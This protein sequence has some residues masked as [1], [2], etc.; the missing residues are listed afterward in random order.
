MRGERGKLHRTQ[1]CL[2]KPNVPTSSNHLAAHLSSQMGSMLDFISKRRGPCRCDGESLRLG[3]CSGDWGCVAATGA[4]SWSLRRGQCRCDGGTGNMVN[5]MPPV[6]LR[7]G[8]NE[9][10]RRGRARLVWL[11]CTENA[12][13]WRSGTRPEKTG[14]GRRESA[15]MRS[16][17]R[18]CENRE[19]AGEATL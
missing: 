11:S 13:F 18:Q 7:N 12:V 19:S 4:V 2:I 5:S 8:S 16:R 6:I 14:G 3:Q 9:A 1:F 15:G 17:R 10:R